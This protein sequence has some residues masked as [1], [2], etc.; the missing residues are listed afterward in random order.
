MVAP[1][2]T[3]REYVY[4]SRR[5]VQEVLDSAEGPKERSRVMRLGAQYLGLGFDASQSSAQPTKGRH[6]L[7]Q[8]AD[9]LLADLAV[10]GWDESAN[11]CRGSG[12]AIWANLGD[13]TSRTRVGMVGAI[14]HTDAPRP[15]LYC[16]FGS[17]T[18]F[19]TRSEEIGNSRAFGWTSSS[20]QAVDALLGLGAG[21][22]LNMDE[23]AAFAAMDF[24]E[25]RDLARNAANIVL[26][27]GMVEGLKDR[28]LY[29]S[30]HLRGY[31]IGRGNMEWLARTY[32]WQED[33]YVHDTRYDVVIGAP[34]YL[35]TRDSEPF[36]Q[37]S[38][39]G[40]R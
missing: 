26:G 33:V 1:L 19:P 13:S 22:G 17:I 31:T 32:Y 21:G 18:N 40:S 3:V 23:D 10:P 20:N 30:A 7:A 24:L 39:G 28:D 25:P 9:E 6:G 29:D 5:L 37:F 8:Q 16:L 2:T 36:E 11:Y 12:E 14:V 4:F 15:R 38:P 35:R 34:L 27:Q